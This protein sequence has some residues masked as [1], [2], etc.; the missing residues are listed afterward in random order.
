MRTY[1]TEE[2][3]V[4]VVGAG[5]GGLATGLELGER[6]VD[7]LVI[8][9]R[10]TSST[11][12]RATGL[13][14]ETMALIRGWGIEAEVQQAGFRSQPVI[15]ICS[16]LVGPELR[17]VPRDDRAWS[18]AQDYLEPIL[19]ERTR[20]AG[21]RVVYGC[22]LK[23]LEIGADSVLATVVDRPTGASRAIQARYVVGADGAYSV[24]RAAAGIALSRLR[25]YGDWISILFRS[26]L[27]DYTGDPP[28]MV[29]GI[30]NPLP[31]GVIVPTDASDRWIR[32]LPWNPQ[33]GERIEE[34]D[35]ARCIALVRSAAGVPELPVTIVAV[36]AFQMVAAIVNRYRA[37][38]AL[39][40][41]DAAHIFTPATGMGLNIALRDGPSVAHY[42]AQAIRNGDSPEALDAY[43]T[44][45]RP[46]AEWALAAELAATDDQHVA[47]VP[48]RLG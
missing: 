33:A 43:E 28:C 3:Q 26:P 9:R 20:A 39:L 42:L 22:E 17:R 32:G 11:Y 1:Q 10:P 30:E 12:P 14:G 13:S 7:A 29:Y 16:S 36:Q 27:R 41:G 35:E 8:E 34:Y 25:R 5:A 21:T 40:V 37:G 18:C 19:S 4:L 31:A 44:E 38:R 45:R 23:S 24:V 15:S 47:G 46:V 2:T 6:S 48:W